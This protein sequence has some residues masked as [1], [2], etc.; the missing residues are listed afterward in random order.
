MS[1]KAPK[2]FVVVIPEKNS[3][4]D[5][6]KSLEKENIYLRSNLGTIVSL[7]FKKKQLANAQYQAYKREISWQDQ[8]KK[9]REQLKVCTEKRM[10]CKKELKEKKYKY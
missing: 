8:L 7:F 9:F 4:K 6:I 2:P 3:L 5:T 10:I 1:F